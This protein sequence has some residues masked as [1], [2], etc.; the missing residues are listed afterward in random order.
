MKAKKKKTLDCTYIARRCADCGVEWFG[1]AE[2]YG[3]DIVYY[4]PN[5]A[6]LYRKKWKD[7]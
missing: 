4:A 5:F 3:T 1:Y 6:H 7:K 2:F